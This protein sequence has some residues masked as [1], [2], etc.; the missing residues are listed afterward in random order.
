[1]SAEDF[2]MTE[3]MEF[4]KSLRGVAKKARNV[5]EFPDDESS[6]REVLQA[7]GELE[8]EARLRHSEDLTR[9]L[10]SLRRLVEDQA[11]ASV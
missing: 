1:M 7:I 10:V 11:L 4:A 2:S 5:L 8:D 3:G 9:W 6:A